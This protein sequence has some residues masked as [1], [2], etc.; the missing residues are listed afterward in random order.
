MGR[1]MHLHRFSCHTADERV[2]YPCTLPSHLARQLMT[3][4][5]SHGQ[6]AY[7]CRHCAGLLQVV[8]KLH[9]LLKPF[10]L[11]R[12]KADVEIALPR[13]QEMLLYAPMSEE[14]KKINQQL[15]DKTLGVG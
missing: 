3:L 13:K 7:S 6:L 4:V 11:R 8:S 5:D 9:N 14:Q 10:M 12:L 1:A 15:L 2:Q